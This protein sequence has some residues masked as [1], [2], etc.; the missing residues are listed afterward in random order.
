[1]GNKKKTTTTTPITK[2]KLFWHYLFLLFPRKYLCDWEFVCFCF[3]AFCQHTHTVAVGNCLFST[4]LFFSVLFVWLGP[5][6]I[7]YFRIDGYIIKAQYT[8]PTLTCFTPFIVRGMETVYLCSG[9]RHV[10]FIMSLIWIYLDMKHTHK[11]S[12]SL[13]YT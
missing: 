1:M 3:S 9:G 7:Y 5:I 8:I 10:F 4:P 13:R 6:T 2:E 12:L 11:P